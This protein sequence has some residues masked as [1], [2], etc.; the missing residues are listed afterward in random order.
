[1]RR[2][3]G[4][5]AMASLACAAV[6][7][8]Y[9]TPARSADHQDAPGVTADPSADINDVF[10]WMDGN[11][12]VLAMTTYPNA[13]ASNSF[14]NAVQYVF[15][16]GS[17]TTFQPSLPTT[18]VDVIATFDNATPQNIQLWVGN[19]NSGGEYVTGNANVSAG[20]SSTDGKV[21]VYAGLVAD[22]F[23]FNLDGFKSV[24]TDVEEAAAT[25]GMDGGLQFDPYGC[26]ELSGAV[27]DTLKGQL[28]T[29]PGGINA[30]QDHFAGFDAL[31]IVVSVDKGLLTQNG[32]A[33]A[34][35][36]WGAT[37]SSPTAS[38]AG[39]E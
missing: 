14:S 1:M 16:T 9:S 13:M 33:P 25:A 30:A 31:A 27:A 39:A 15:H 4:I 17:A 18:G 32:A 5:A 29:A 28:G 35:S 26:P 24:V 11:N 12:V 2:S 34:V 6:I 38:D 3:L 8:G 36:V 19:P 7:S 21:K 23:F 10:T 20:L 37:Y 22:P